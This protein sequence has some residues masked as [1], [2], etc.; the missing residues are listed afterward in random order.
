[1]MSGIVGGGARRS[2]LQLRQPSPQDDAQSVEAVPVP[3]T[4]VRAFTEHGTCRTMR[5]VAG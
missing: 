5:G 4:Q 1:M 3:R 2:D